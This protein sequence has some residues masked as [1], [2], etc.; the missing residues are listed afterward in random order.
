MKYIIL[1]PY[2]PL[3]YNNLQKFIWEKFRVTFEIHSKVKWLG[4]EALSLSWWRDEFTFC[5]RGDVKND[6]FTDILK[7]VYRNLH[8][9]NYFENSWKIPKIH[10][11]LK[12]SAKDTLQL[13][14]LHSTTFTCCK[15]T[16]KTPEKRV[17]SVQVN[18]TNTKLLCCLYCELWAYFTNCSSVSIV[19]FEQVNADR[20]LTNWKK[21]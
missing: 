20:A 5:H 2:F 10:L 1:N 16:M 21:N 18:I 17:K 9:K 8:L 14:G 13:A 11:L 6:F 19:D 7:P 12:L 4:I 3:S 15:W